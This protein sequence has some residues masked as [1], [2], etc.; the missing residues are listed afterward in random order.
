VSSDAGVITGSILLTDGIGYIGSHL[1]QLL[2]HFGFRVTL[3]DL[4]ADGTDLADAPALERVLE[5]EA[6]DVVVH[7][8]AAVGVRESVEDPESHRRNNVFATLNLL[9]GMKRHGLSRVGNMI[10]GAWARAIR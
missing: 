1:A 2:G 6:A 3:L 5:R 7:L 4:K 10:G 8:A 9:E